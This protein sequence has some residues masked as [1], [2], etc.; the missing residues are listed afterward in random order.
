MTQIHRTVWARND[1]KITLFASILTQAEEK[2]CVLWWICGGHKKHGVLYCSVW[3]IQSVWLEVVRRVRCTHALLQVRPWR[4]DHVTGLSL[5]ETRS[6]R[7]IVTAFMPTRCQRATS[8][9]YK[10]RNMHSEWLYGITC[11]LLCFLQAHTEVHVEMNIR[12]WEWLR[13]FA[14][15]HDNVCTRMF[16][17][18]IPTI[19]ANV[20]T[21]C[22]FQDCCIL[23][24]ASECR[25]LSA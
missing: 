8:I 5:Q 7:W 3:V 19:R 1:Q 2:E 4:L 23:R 12:S 15:A 25:F 17:H 22:H 11:L 18:L 20:L 10:S 24:C 14:H 6:L 16:P 13:L 21:K 9:W